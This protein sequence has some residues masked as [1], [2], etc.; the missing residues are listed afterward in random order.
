MATRKDRKSKTEPRP[1]QRKSKLA[2]ECAFPS[3]QERLPLHIS[4]TY[5]VAI[6][7]RGDRDLVAKSSPGY[8]GDP[9]PL[10]E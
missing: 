10:F 1:K 8:T 4:G 7:T 9:N 2:G 5:Q 6:G 3:Q